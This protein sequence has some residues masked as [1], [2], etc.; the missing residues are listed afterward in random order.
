M[1]SLKEHIEHTGD[2]IR[3][4]SICSKGMQIEENRNQQCRKSNKSCAKNPSQLSISLRVKSESLKLMFEALLT[5]SPIL[6]CL[7]DLT[8]SDLH[9]TLCFPVTLPLLH[10]NFTLAVPCAWKSPECHTVYSLTSLTSLLTCHPPQEDLCR[11]P[12]LNLHPHSGPPCPPSPFH[13]SRQHSHHLTFYVLHAFTC[14]YRPQ[15]GCKLLE[16]RGVHLHCQEQC[17]THY[18]HSVTICQ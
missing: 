10:Q 3:D 6:T 16:D 5:T 12:C 4:P 2:R 7:S 1:K 18:R 14:I 11:P 9:F 15:L 17:Q 13:S 8:S